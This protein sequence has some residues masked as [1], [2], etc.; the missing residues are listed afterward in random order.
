MILGG[1]HDQ[2]FFRQ[3]SNPNLMKSKLIPMV[4]ILAM[5]LQAESTLAHGV[6]APSLR[7]VKPPRIPGLVGGKNP[8]IVNQKWARVLGKAL[9][10]D[11]NVGSDGTAC[12]TCHYHAGA[13]E[14]SRN[15]LNTGDFD[16]DRALGLTFQ[17]TQ[18]GGNPSGGT[19]TDYQYNKRDFHFWSFQDPDNQQSTLLYSTDDVS[20]SSGTFMATLQS[21]GMAGSDHDVCSQ[22]ADAI[23][24]QAGTGKNTRQVTN[25]NAPSVINAAFNFR[26]FWDGRANNIFNGQSPWGARD[27]D[28][29]VWIK[30]AGGL[31]KIQIRLKNASLASQALGPPTNTVEMSCAQRRFPDIGQKLL[32]RRALEFQDV[33]PDDSVLGKERDAS[34]KG[35]AKTY[36]E[37]IR[38]AFSSR[39]WAGEGQVEVQGAFYS[40]MEANFA[41]FFGL[42]AQMYENTLIS[43][44][45]RY[46]TPLTRW[47]GLYVNGGKVPSG[48]TETERRGLVRFLDGHCQVCHAG[49]TFSA[50]VNPA[51][52]QKQNANGPIL[53]D[54]SAFGANGVEYTLRDVG[55][56]NT[57]VVPTS[58]D[59]GQNN[60][61]PF[62]NPL[63]YTQQYINALLRGNDNLIDPVK[64]YACDMEYPFEV[65]WPVDSL[66]NDPNGYQRGKCRR[67]RGLAKIPAPGPLAAQLAL[68]LQGRAFYSVE[69]VFKIPSLRN[70][71]LTAPFMHNGGMKSLEEVVHF[72]NRGANVANRDILPQLV[73]PQGFGP[74][75]QAELVAFLKALTDDRVRW[76]QAPFDHPSLKLPLGTTS[77]TSPLDPN[78]ANDDFE[79]LPAVGK[80]GRSAAQGPLPSFE[81]DLPD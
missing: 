44:K 41:F 69:G 26:N 37:L 24:H 35:L 33:A 9:F 3:T 73:F 46:D 32:D 75:E 61:D 39:Y 62:G 80:F 72:Y 66:V 23:Y 60:T 30:R 58:H 31:Q 52:F 57:G 14:R 16:R 45:T 15:Q 28:A 1:R 51:I 42:A 47:S 56:A 76:E 65:D 48:L 78:F 12:A 19:N 50:A 77:G 68:P 63:S 10:W 7:G 81:Q 70:V 22:Q 36:R 43:D 13:D 20:G 25:R 6:P 54:R 34:G 29:G 64:V 5:M 55:F 71:E 38:K 40:Q 59:P 79:L 17:P 18:S 27:P 2:S 49:P 67:L 21:L 4:A 8:I 74:E 53:V 11:M